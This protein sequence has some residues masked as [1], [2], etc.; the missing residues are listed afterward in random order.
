M[1]A[2]LAS[3]AEYTP[4]PQ[5]QIIRRTD[6]SLRTRYPHLITEIFEVTPYT[7]QIVF[8]AAQEDAATIGPIFDN[9]IRPLTAHV[10]LS[11]HR[12]DSHIR[13]LRP[14][15]DV[16]AS[17]DMAGL[18]LRTIDLLNLLLSRYPDCGVSDLATDARSRRVTLITPTPI[19]ARVLDQIAAFFR[20][21]DLDWPIDVEIKKAERP[22]HMGAETD[23]MFVWA[24]ALRPVAPRYVRDDE[25]FWFGNIDDIAKG[26]LAA[27]RF[28]GMRP[29]AFRCYLD[30][31][32]GGTHVNLRQMLMLYDEVWCSLPLAHE[33][34]P[35]LARQHLSRDDILHVVSSGRLRIVSTQPEE[36]LDIRLLEAIAERE[37]TAIFGRRTTA[38]LL[39]ADVAETASISHL[40]NP[41][42]KHLAAPM[43]KA[44]AEVIG[45]SPESIIQS[46]FW[47]LQARRSALQS[48]LDRGSKGGPAIGLGRA[49]AAHVKALRGVDLEL[50]F[51]IFSETVHI[52]HALNAT[53]YPGL[54][55]SEA[56]VNLMSMLGG[57]LNFHRGFNT[58]IAA[59]WAANERRRAD[60]VTVM[61]ALPLFEF[62][63]VS[64]DDFLEDTRL[65]STRSTG[66]ALMSRLS[67][68]DAEAREDEVKKLI[69]E[70]RRLERN[71][72][73]GLLSFDTVDTGISVA[74]IL[75]GFT[76]PPI[77]GLLGL[78][79]PLVEQ[80]RRSPVIDRFVDDFLTDAQP[81]TGRNR[82]LDF[83]SRIKRVAEFRRPRI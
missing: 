17:S 21:L 32:L 24:S 48:I 3:P 47:P 53:V 39:M 14:M 15:T 18:P 65:G 78:A 83:L 29:D 72:G 68:L 11:N 10:K 80:M 42:L 49:L 22:R 44:V 50:E 55:Q 51:S 43:A 25:A 9:Q 30:L 77:A 41:A 13:Q 1:T 76:Y 59:A 54:D 33:L 34:E 38:G 36:R 19:A 20:S 63:H 66:R 69:D 56:E 73:R 64:I 27:D 16:E 28:P 6:A 5:D 4:A 23:P 79:K 67:N 46:L 7:F 75:A 40:N 70:L 74:S 57:E 37:P 58:A 52:G 31:T 8:D 12:P 60:G 35:F 45:G 2:E 81:M 61:P 62:E 26:L 82:D 71:Q